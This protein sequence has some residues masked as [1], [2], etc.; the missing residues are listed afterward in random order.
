MEDVRPRHVRDVVLELRKTSSLEP[1]TIRHVFAT[2]VTLFRS[3]LADELITAT[4]CVVAKRVLP[5]KIDKDPSWRAGAIYSR[6][7]WNAC[8]P[9]LASPEIVEC[10][11][12]S[13]E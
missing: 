7:G 11:M 1:R 2:L 10:S 5:K 4:P 12:G 8:C 9:T 6:E 13:R 3:A